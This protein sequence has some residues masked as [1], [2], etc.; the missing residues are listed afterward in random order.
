MRLLNYK[1]QNC[2]GIKVWKGSDCES[3]GEKES[4]E[5]LAMRDAAEQMDKTLVAAEMVGY[6]EQKMLGKESNFGEEWRI[7][8][9]WPGYTSTCLRYL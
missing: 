7:A 3:E 5:P 1:W 2:F 8:A 6:K 4:K 9:S